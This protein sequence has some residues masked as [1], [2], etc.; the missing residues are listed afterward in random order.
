MNPAEDGNCHLEV[1]CV[2]QP[3]SNKWGS[4]P[5]EIDQSFRS[6]EFAVPSMVKMPFE[7]CCRLDPEPVF[8][9]AFTP[10]VPLPF[11]QKLV[12]ATDDDF[13]RQNWRYRRRNEDLG[14]GR[15]EREGCSLSVARKALKIPS[16]FK[17][18]WI[19]M[20]DE[21]LVTFVDDRNNRLM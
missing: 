12:G 18:A 2:L 19:V 6:S 21:K 17:L 14:F 4:I 10:A 8:F 7:T 11:F 5:P 16:G 20:L 13:V 1:L 15:P 9:G 3:A